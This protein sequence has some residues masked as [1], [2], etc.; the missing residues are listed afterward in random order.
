MKQVDAQKLAAKIKTEYGISEHRHLRKQHRSSRIARSN[1]RK[2]SVSGWK[3][4]R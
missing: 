4:V 3:I 2:M 1:W